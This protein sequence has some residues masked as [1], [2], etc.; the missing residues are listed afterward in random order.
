MKV[1]LPFVCVVLFVAFT[2]VDTVGGSCHPINDFDCF[3]VK[4]KPSAN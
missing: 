3:L 1:L 4:L 2:T